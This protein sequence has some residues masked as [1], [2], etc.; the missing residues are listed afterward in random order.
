MESSQN[1]NVDLEIILR[2]V[3]PLQDFQEFANYFI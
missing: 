2:K 3:H 1:L